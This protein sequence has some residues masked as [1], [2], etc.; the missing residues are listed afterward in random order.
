[1]VLRWWLEEECKMAYRVKYQYPGDPVTEVT[2]MFGGE[3]L[4]AN[5]N[6]EIVI[7]CADSEQHIPVE[8]VVCDTCN[9]SVQA[10][11]PCA[12]V[13]GHLYCWQCYKEWVK[14]HLTEDLGVVLFQVA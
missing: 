12:V 7:S 2:L 5:P 6:R 14:P 9:A 8:D 4:A 3:F 10:T 11:E 13:I 1:M